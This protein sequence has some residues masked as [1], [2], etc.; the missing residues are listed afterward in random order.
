MMLSCKNIKRGDQGK[1]RYD[2]LICGGV[3]YFGH[4]IGLILS[5]G[6]QLINGYLPLTTN[7]V[8]N[9]FNWVQRTMILKFLV[10]RGALCVLHGIL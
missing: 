5:F 10:I 4:S 2:I 8:M 9:K 6:S 7:K 1:I 3:S